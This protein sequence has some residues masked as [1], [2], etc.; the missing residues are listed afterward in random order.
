MT[1]TVL[2]VLVIGGAGI[3]A[4]I[5]LPLLARFA[6]ARSAFDQFDRRPW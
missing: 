4:R 1:L 3:A 5:E 2:P 6:L